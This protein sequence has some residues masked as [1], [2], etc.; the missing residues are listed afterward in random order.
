MGLMCVTLTTHVSNIVN[1]VINSVPNSLTILMIIDAKWLAILASTNVH[2]LPC[3]EISANIRC[4]KSINFIN[5]PILL[6]LCHAHSNAEEAVLTL[7]IFIP[8]MTNLI[9]LKLIFVIKSTLA[10]A[11]AKKEEYVR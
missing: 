5:A 2:Y 11:T 3:V 9:I 10:K 8:C 1:S 6:V 4:K 7:I